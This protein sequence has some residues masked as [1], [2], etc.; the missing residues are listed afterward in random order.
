MNFYD[1]HE[2]YMNSSSDSE[3]SSSSLCSFPTFTPGGYVETF[4]DEDSETYFTSDSFEEDHFCEEFQ[5]FHAENYASDDF[6][7][8]KHVRFC[9]NNLHQFKEN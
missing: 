6:E 5:S 1:D 8:K 4:D 3:S 2:L 7:T 9:L